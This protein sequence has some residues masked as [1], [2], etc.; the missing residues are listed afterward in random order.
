MFSF[1][2]TEVLAGKLTELARQVRIEVIGLLVQGIGEAEFK[3]P[4][5]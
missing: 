3:V 5:R 2:M 1:K 4:L